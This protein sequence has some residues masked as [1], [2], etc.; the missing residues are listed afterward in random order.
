VARLTPSGRRSS[1]RLGGALRAARVVA[2]LAAT[3]APLWGPTGCFSPL[4]PPCAFS[5][6]EQER[7]CPEHYTCG[8]DGICHREGATGICVL[9]PPADAAPPDAGDAGTASD[10][11]DAS[12]QD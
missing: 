2:V 6:V 7:R 9:T 11:S 12:Q 1:G 3:A 4:Q 5:C 10:A 8:D